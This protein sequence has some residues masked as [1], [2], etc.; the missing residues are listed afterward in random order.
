MSGIK[1]QP[2]SVACFYGDRGDDV[3]CDDGV[4]CDDADGAILRHLW[5]LKYF[6]RPS[7]RCLFDDFS[8]E[9]EN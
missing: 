3:R 6:S 8:I 1:L 7:R 2:G 5:G 9:T 4:H